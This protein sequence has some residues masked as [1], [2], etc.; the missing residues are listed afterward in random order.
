MSKLEN[1]FVKVA[2]IISLIISAI[3]LSYIL[4][5][6]CHIFLKKR[7]FS[8]TPIVPSVSIV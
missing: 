5:N 7:K 1:Q 4:Y 6:C 2:I 3:I 8:V